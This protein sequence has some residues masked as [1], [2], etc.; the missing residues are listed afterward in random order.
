MLTL[1]L[2]YDWVSTLKDFLC[3]LRQERTARSV[4]FTC[5]AHV[6]GIA[7]KAFHTLELEEQDFLPGGMGDL[8]L[9]TAGCRIVR[10]A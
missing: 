2:L 6:A 5:P 7:P 8:A 4:G 10:C 1:Q 3:C 9:A